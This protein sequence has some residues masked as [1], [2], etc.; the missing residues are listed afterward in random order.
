M[1]QN[2]KPPNAT[3][4]SQKQQ[5]QGSHVEAANLERSS[6]NSGQFELRQRNSQNWD[7]DG[8]NQDLK[9]AEQQGSPTAANQSFQSVHRSPGVVFDGTKLKTNLTYKC[10]L[11][12]QKTETAC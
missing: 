1:G 11:T 2:T 4:E 9:E 7:V 12:P 6:S 5:K 10:P 8:G 3:K